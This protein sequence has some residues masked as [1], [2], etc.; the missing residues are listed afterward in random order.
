MTATATAGSAWTLARMPD[1]TGKTIVITGAN[2]GIGYEA[3]RGFAARNAHVVLAVRNEG[4]G[5]AAAAAI[6]GVCGAII[7]N[8]TTPRNCYAYDRYGRRIRESC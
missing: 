3:A 1:L 7:G 2:S 6:G 5:R 8:A 4:K